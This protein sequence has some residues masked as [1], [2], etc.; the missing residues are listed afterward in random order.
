[1]KVNGT[2]YRSLWPTANGAVEIIDQRA[3]PHAF[4]TRTLRSVDD[5]IDAIRTMAVRGAPLIGVAGAYG[6][7]LAM[8]HDSRRWAQRTGLTKVRCRDRSPSWST[9]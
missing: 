1:M 4:A 6:M 7:A 5:V 2:H 3:L 8:R 9:D